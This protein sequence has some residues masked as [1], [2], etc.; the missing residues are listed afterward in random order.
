MNQIETKLGAVV[1]GVVWGLLVTVAATA[2]AFILHFI[3]GS[4][5]F[6]VVPIFGII[7]SIISIK[8][9]MKDAEEFQ[10][11]KAI[12]EMCNKLYQIGFYFGSSSY[13]VGNY[14]QA[15]IPQSS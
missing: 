11:Q 3:I 8:G 9:D 10:R 5:I 1:V 15:F 6:A 4:W 7:V 14:S 2:I 13:R 12:K